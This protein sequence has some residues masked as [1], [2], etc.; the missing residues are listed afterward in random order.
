METIC[1]EEQPNPTVKSTKS[2][3]SFEAHLTAHILGSR[4]RNQP[5][6]R[7]LQQLT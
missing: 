7:P 6:F 5:L 3:I 2:P 4:T 1:Y